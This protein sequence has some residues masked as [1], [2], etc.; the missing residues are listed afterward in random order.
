M[1]MIAVPET[2]T[3]ALAMA[4]PASADLPEAP[5]AMP[6]QSLEAGGL[7]AMMRA[8]FGATRRMVKH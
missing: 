5:L 2:D 7:I 6:V 1:N 8:M 3:A 4:I